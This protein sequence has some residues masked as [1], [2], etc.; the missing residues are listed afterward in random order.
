MKID[1]FSMHQNGK[2]TLSFM[3]QALGLM[4]DLDL[5]TE[6]L[7]WMGDTRFMVGFLRGGMAQFINGRSAFG[8][9]FLEVLS[10]KPCPIQ[11]SIKIAEQN[12][13]IMA[14]ALWARREN[15]AK[16]I[17]LSPSDPEEPVDD[18][19]SLQKPSEGKEVDWI[20]FDKP[21][22]YLYAG[23][24]PYV[25]RFVSLCLQLQ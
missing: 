18:T 9:M 6:H 24:G 11:L 4:A 5:G 13:H 15:E 12:K 14:E 17:Q 23:Q 25:A 7:R 2:R 10:F 1:L 21:I 3:S 20:V 16:E 19:P 8:L 22:L